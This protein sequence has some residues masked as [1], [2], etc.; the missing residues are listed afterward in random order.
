MLSRGTSKLSA[1]DQWVQ[2]CKKPQQG[3]EK[4]HVGPVYKE[5]P[6]VYKECIGSV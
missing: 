2:A 4:P 3:D 1:Q 5:C 6:H